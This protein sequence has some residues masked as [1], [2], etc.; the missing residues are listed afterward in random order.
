MIRNVAVIPPNWKRYPQRSP[1]HLAVAVLYE[2]RIVGAC[3]GPS[4]EDGFGSQGGKP[5]RRSIDRRYRI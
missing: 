1:S 2:R 3:H 4:P 5:L